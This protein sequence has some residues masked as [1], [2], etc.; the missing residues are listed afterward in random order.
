MKVGNTLVILSILLTTLSGLA[1]IASAE[2]EQSPDDLTMFFGN[3]SLGG[4]WA[5]LG[6]EIVAYIDDEPRGNVTITTEGQYRYLAVSGDESDNGKTVTF[7]VAELDADDAK[8]TVD[9]VPGS[10]P[11]SVRLNLH[12][13]PAPTTPAPAYG[14]S[15][16]GSG[17]SGLLP[18]TTST[19]E[20]AS[21]VSGEAGSSSTSSTTEPVTSETE[22]T[23]TPEEPGAE[24]D[25]DSGFLSGFGMI[26][27]VI[28][29]AGIIVAVYLVSKRS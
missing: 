28:V 23:T 27:A 22:T 2:D 14:G 8:W 5:Q 6:T 10:T 15:G 12:V 29:V 3:V 17:G 1:V 4:E 9:W 11:E 20:N 7:K 18:A 16:G 19:D 25:D 13:G 26:L 21:A 24:S